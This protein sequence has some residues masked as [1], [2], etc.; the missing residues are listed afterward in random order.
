MERQT[1][2]LVAEMERAAKLGRQL[3]AAAAPARR[4]MAALGLEEGDPPPPPPK[5]ERPSHPPPP[6]DRPSFEVE[7]PPKDVLAALKEA[8]PGFKPTG[9]WW[10]HVETELKNAHHRS[11]Q[12]GHDAFCAAYPYWT[13]EDLLRHLESEGRVKRPPAPRGKSVCERLRELHTEDP[14]FAETAPERVLAKR[15]EKKSAGS[16]SKSAYWQFTLKPKRMEARARAQ[17][18]RA[19]VRSNAATPS[20]AQARS[21]NWDQREAVRRIDAEIDSELAG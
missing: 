13:A 15:I 3:E 9:N 18:A 10:A 19:G 17:L 14:D 8:F 5:P 20:K 2:P 1:A 4:M 6:P 12:Q 7:D 11:N 16:L 21:E